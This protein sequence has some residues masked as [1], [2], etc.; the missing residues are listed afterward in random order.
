MI[1]YLIFLAVI[2]GSILTMHSCFNEMILISG[3]GQV[4]SES[5]AISDFNEVNLNISGVVE[6]SKDSL[7]SIDVSDY[8]NLLPHIRT[9][10]TGKKMII[11]HDPDNL[12]VRNSVA[13]IKIKMPALNNLIINGSGTFNILSG[14]DELNSIQIIGSGNVNVSDSFNTANLSIIISG[15]GNV[16]AVGRADQLNTNITGS[17]NIN[18]YGLVAQNATCLI[19]GSGNTYVHVVQNLNASIAGSGNIVYMG[20][21]KLTVNVSGSGTVKSR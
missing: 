8:E 7:Y 2:M 20:S 1:R 13:K 19:T 6:I 11:E 3:S 12:N 9:S 10:V 14:F 15:S 18:L 5:R 16:M 17:G 21:P 4:K